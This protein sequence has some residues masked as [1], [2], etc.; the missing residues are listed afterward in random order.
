MTMLIFRETR[1]PAANLPHWPVK[2]P[3]FRLPLQAPQQVQMP[4]VSSFRLH[5]AIVPAAIPVASLRRH[6][7]PA[8]WPG[9]R[10]A[11]P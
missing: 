3:A 6:F 8:E 5:F 2:Y 9:S 10:Y 4:A 1:F 7:L 11:F